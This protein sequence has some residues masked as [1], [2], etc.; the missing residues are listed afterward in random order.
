FTTQEADAMSDQQLK[1]VLERAIKNEEDA[2]T[3]YTQLHDI[4][5]D[6]TAREALRFL[7]VEELRHKE[8][9][10]NYLEGR[11]AANSLSTDQVIDYGVAQ[12]NDKPD[13]QK[14]MGTAEVFLV[15]AHR[16]WNAHKFY[17]GLAALQ[18]EGEVKQLLTEFAAQELRHK[19]KVE[20]LYSNTAFP[21]TAG[22]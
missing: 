3:F 2:H 20:Y 11:V 18:P 17:Q 12:Y 7:A 4:V 21:Q 14:D 9:L 19:E 8:F 22:G 15:A 13:I 10:V 6:A 16:E 1:T 5:Q